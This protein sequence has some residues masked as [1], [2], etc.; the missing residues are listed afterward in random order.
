MRKN[1]LK[2]FAILALMCAL[3]YI[4]CMF[5]SI[6]VATSLY[7][8]FG[9]VFCLLTALMLGGFEGGIAGAI[10]MGI[11]DLTDGLHALSFPKTIVCKM[12]MAI[13]VGIFAHRVFK[14][15]ETKSKKDLFLSLLFGIIANIIFEIGFGYIYYRFI[16]GT[17]NDTFIVFFV[18]KIVSVSF[19]SLITLIVTFIIYYPLYNRVKS[20]L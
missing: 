13:V 2:R 7:V 16:L 1:N 5:L 6:K 11:A 4:G 14:V 20:Y 12:A 17:V 19:T 10:G 3:C 18:S 15:N 9:N 8:H